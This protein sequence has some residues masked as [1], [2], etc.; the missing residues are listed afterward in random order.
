MACDGLRT[1]DSAGFSAYNE[2]R[3][4]D[5][6]LRKSDKGCRR[7]YRN[8]RLNDIDSCTDAMGGGQSDIARNRGDR[9]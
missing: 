8:C 2:R 5:R 4:H 7:L 1:G 3:M 9:I 6:A